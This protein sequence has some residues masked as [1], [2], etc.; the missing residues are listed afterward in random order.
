MYRYPQYYMYSPCTLTIIKICRVCLSV[1]LSAPEISG[2]AQV[3]FVMFSL[4]LSFYLFDVN[5]N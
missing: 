2:A 1:C 3:L 4:I 5:T